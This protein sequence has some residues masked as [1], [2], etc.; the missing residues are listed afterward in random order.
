[1]LLQH[2][3]CRLLI[4]YLSHHYFCLCGI[5]VTSYVTHTMSCLKCPAPRSNPSHHHPIP[6]R[7]SPRP[8]PSRASPP[9]IPFSHDRRH[10]HCPFS[11]T[12]WLSAAGVA[13][14][15]RSPLGLFSSRCQFTIVAGRV[16]IDAVAVQQEEHRVGRQRICLPSPALNRHQ[17]RR[18]VSLRSAISLF[19]TTA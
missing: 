15:L 1:M 14:P 4:S 9:P 11:S 12:V 10:H 2:P 8:I 18:P 17:R 19:F 13:P 6:T 5:E 3:L 7:V 16:S